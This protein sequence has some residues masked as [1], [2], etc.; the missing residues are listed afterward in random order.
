MMWAKQP[1]R[2]FARPRLAMMSIYTVTLCLISLAAF[3][4]TK[5]HSVTLAEAEELVVQ[6]LQ[7][8]GVEGEL[9]VT[10]VGR[11][12][13]ELVRQEVPIIMDMA[14]FEMDEGTQR[15]SGVLSFSTEAD[16]NR[17]SRNLG[18][19]NVAGRYDVMMDVPV[20]KYRLNQED[21]IRAGDI[22]WQKVPV[23]RTRRDTITDETELV[24]M[25]PVR[26]ISP[27]RP[28]RES[29]VSNPPVVSRYKPV[30]MSYQ[31]GR[32]IIKAVGTALQDGAVGERIKVRN[33]DSGME[34]NAI[35]VERGKVN[36]LPAFTMA[37]R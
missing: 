1:K 17:P 9:E 14:Y 36:V 35:V 3:A 2:F 21:V 8:R 10:I 13:D 29:E 16:L 32:I 18:R 26:S 31:T 6:A 24:G 27:G 5:T 30:Q 22:E 12:T 25:S 20:V 23:A 7:E 15:F 19:L 33:D 11:R 28:I 37:I 34:L 4:T